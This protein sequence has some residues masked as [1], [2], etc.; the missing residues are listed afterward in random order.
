MAGQGMS[1]GIALDFETADNGADSACALAM[2]RVDL[3]ACTVGGTLYHLIRPPR[4]R[5]YFTEIHGITW[6]MVKDKPVFA[7]LW[8][9]FAAFAEGAEFFIAHNASF[10]RGI[11]Y[12][13]CRA[14]AI[15]PPAAPFLCTVK[16]SRRRLGLPH[17]RLNDVCAHLGIELNHHHAESDALASA[18]IFLHLRGLGLSPDEMRIK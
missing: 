10:D 1:F 17:N 14:A 6:P 8:P 12:G 11:L 3:D 5:I 2:A 7:E 13:C 9:E 15:A 16:G 18:R 4:K